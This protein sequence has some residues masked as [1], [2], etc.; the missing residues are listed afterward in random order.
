MTADTTMEYLDSLMVEAEVNDT[1]GVLFSWTQ[2]EGTTPGLITDS[3]YNFIITPNFFK[4]L[5]A[6]S[7]SSDL[8][9]L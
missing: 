6:L 5:R 2:L 8:S 7:V 1:A 4:H 9:I 3:S